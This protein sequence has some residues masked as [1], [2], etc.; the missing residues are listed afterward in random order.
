MS[1]CHLVGI[2]AATHTRTCSCGSTA[3]SAGEFH[4]HL[5]GPTL[6]ELVAEVERGWALLD[7]SWRAW[8]LER[9]RIELNRNEWPTP[10]HRTPQIRESI[11]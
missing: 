1:N 8:L 4:H 5:Y 7:R 11:G 9:D 6:A 2:D 3:R 10:I